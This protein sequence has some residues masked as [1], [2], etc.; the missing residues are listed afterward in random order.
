MNMP[1]QPTHSLMTGSPTPSRSGSVH[2]NASLTRRPRIRGRT[3]TFSEGC[4]RSQPTVR[5]ADASTVSSEPP[6]IADFLVAKPRYTVPPPLPLRSPRRLGTSFQ[7]QQ[8]REA[9]SRDPMPS[10]SSTRSGRG[11]TLKNTAS[12][13]ELIDLKN[14]SGCLLSYSLISKSCPIGHRWHARL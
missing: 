2:S 8:A 9:G 6:T 13:Q 1:S 4:K 11:R 3:Q 5:A 10:P 12:L 14:V 7:D